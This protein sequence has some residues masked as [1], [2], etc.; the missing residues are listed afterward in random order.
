[1][2]PIARSYPARQ[3]GIPKMRAQ[4]DA[5]AVEPHALTAQPRAVPGERWRPVSVHHAVTGNAR[6]AAGAHD[7]ADRPRGKRTT[8]DEG[9][10][11]VARDA[12]RG[13]AP[14]RRVHVL[15]PRVG[16]RGPYCGR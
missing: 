2:D 16:H 14:Y 7:V 1:S 3:S 9:D 11:P 5:P 8:H 12:P 15:R 4:V 13:D 6:V 10:E